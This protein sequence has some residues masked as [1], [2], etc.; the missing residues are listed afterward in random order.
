LY[1]ETVGRLAAADYRQ[2][3]TTLERR[4]RFHRAALHDLQRGHVLAHAA[5]LGSSSDAAVAGA[6]AGEARRALWVETTGL[7]AE[8]FH[9]VADVQAR[10]AKRVEEA[11][12]EHDQRDSLTKKWFDRGLLQ[13]DPID[14]TEGASRDRAA[15]TS[16]RLPDDVGPAL[17]YGGDEAGRAQRRRNL[18]E[19][20]KADPA[21]P[22]GFG[23]RGAFQAPDKD[24]T[25]RSRRASSDFANSR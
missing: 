1:F 7:L 9:G 3:L 13:L 22:G 18:A 15:A 23:L 10:A 20:R 16:G 12:L 21:K 24:A 11:S 19:S 4:M 8:V 17:F 25:A 6:A 14:Q 2:L 5:S